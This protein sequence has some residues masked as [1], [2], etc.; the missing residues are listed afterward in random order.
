[1]KGSIHHSEWPR[2]ARPS[3]GRYKANTRNVEDGSIED[4]DRLTDDD[5]A[6]P[7]YYIKEST[8]ANQRFP[9]SLGIE[10]VLL[11]PVHLTFCL[12]RWDYHKRDITV[13]EYVDGAGGI[14][15]GIAHNA[16][17]VVVSISAGAL[18][19]IAAI[20]FTISL[21]FIESTLSSQH[22]HQ[23]IQDMSQS[24]SSLGHNTPYRSMKTNRNHPTISY[25]YYHNSINH[26]RR[27]YN[28]DCCSR[29]LHSPFPIELAVQLV[30]GCV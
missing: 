16:T 23:C 5:V 28:L 27:S 26:P 13:V 6:Q 7:C 15:A 19:D 3:D 25:R 29:H 30:L 21:L 24:I 2:L 20:V 1:M 9:Q 10:G 14:Y 4:T 18:A 22:S 11:Y 12:T 17:S 8:R